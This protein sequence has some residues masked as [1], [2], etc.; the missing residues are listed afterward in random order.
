MIAAVMIANVR[1]RPDLYCGSGPL[2]FA[3]GY[4]ACLE[5]VNRGEVPEPLP[6]L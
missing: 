4:R 2:I 5:D 3:R 1:L 6:H